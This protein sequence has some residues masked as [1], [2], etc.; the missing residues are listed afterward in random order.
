VIGVFTM[1]GPKEIWGNQEPTV[2]AAVMCTILLSGMFFL[3]YLLVAITKT[4]FEVSKKARDSQ[5]LKKLDAGATGAKMTVNFAPM[6]CILFIGARMRA[7]Q[8][9]PKNGNPQ[10][11]AQNC[12]F[13]CTFSILI[14][15]LL[16]ILM[17]F[18]AKGDCKRGAIEGDVAFTMENARVG[19]AMTIM[20]YLCLAALYVG[21]VIVVYSMF[22][23]QHPDGHSKTP[24]VSP[25]MQCVVALTAQYFFVYILLFICVTIKSFATGQSFNRSDNEQGSLVAFESDSTASKAMTTAIGICDAARNTVMFAPMLSI[26]FIGARMRALQLARDEDGNIPAGAGPQKWVQDAMFLATWAVFVQLIMTMVVAL[27]TAQKPDADG[28]QKIPPGT[29]RAVAITVEVVRYINMITMY[30]GAGLVVSGMF[31]M[32]PQDCQPYSS[33]GLMPGVNVPPPPIPASAKPI[34][35][36]H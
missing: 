19:A 22:V 28:N 5:V 8:I 15:A 24:P 9:D 16:V 27:V 23:I 30:I 7:L 2:S 20:R 10:S 31:L 17:P 29:N 3:I 11:W 4:C 6:L 32:T 1:R 26:L 33:H 35:I 34:H 13:L 21:T 14:Q 12:F 18:L 36:V 25:A